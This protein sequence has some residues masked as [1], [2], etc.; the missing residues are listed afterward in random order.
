MRE[1]TK[2]GYAKFKN[3]ANLHQFDFG[4]FVSENITQEDVLEMLAHANDGR[5]AVLMIFSNDCGPCTLIDE[6]FLRQAKKYR[7]YVFYREEVG[8]GLSPGVKHLP[9]FRIIGKK[10]KIEAELT[11]SNM[12]SLENAIRQNSNSK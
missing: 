8:R 3:I 6:E 11:T 7:D 4:E 2:S 9:T 5:K 10:A 1:R 12:I